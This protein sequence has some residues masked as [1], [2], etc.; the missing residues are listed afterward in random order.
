MIVSI[1]PMYMCNLKCPFCY[2]KGTVCSDILNATDLEFIL[3]KINVHQINIYGGEVTL[4]E[5]HYI[6]NLL[7]ICSNYTKSISINSNYTFNKIPNW[8]NRVS[9]GTSIDFSCRPVN[10]IINNGRNIY[11][12]FN[13]KTNIL[14]TDPNNIAYIDRI[15]EIVDENWVHSFRILP[16][17]KTKNNKVVLNFK[18]TE[19]LIYKYYY[20]NKYDR[21]NVKEE[22]VFI[23]PKA[24]LLYI[25]YDNDVEYFSTK[26]TTNNRHC[27]LC[28]YYNKCFNEHPF[29]YTDNY[30]CIG[31]K[32]L[33]KKLHL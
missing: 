12:V 1:F 15:Q 17:V 24:E 21:I 16:C 2:L 14:F 18:N 6:N 13:K 30:D 4:L 25:A 23:S 7:D 22:C 26:S 29:Y 27:L 20:H 31:F 9:L 32:K 8:I 11:K 5:E 33:C 10:K 3:S 19:N 28:E